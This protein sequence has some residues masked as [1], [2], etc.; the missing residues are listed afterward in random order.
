M[1]HNARGTVL[2]AILILTSVLTLA[3]I[4][5]TVLATSIDRNSTHSHSATSYPWW[6]T[7]RATGPPLSWYLA[8]E[9]AVVA[10]VIA[11]VAMSFRLLR[12][13]RRTASAEA[14]F[15]AV[16]LCAVSIESIRPFLA[17]VAPGALG[18]LIR[19]LL[20][21]ALYAG[22]LF[23]ALCL[24]ISSLYVLGV[25]YA[26]VETPFTI[27]ILVCLFFAYSLPLDSSE[28]VATPAYRLGDEGAVAAVFFSLYGFAAL[29]AVIGRF[30]GQ[31]QRGLVQAGAILLVSGGRDLLSFVTY[32][33]LAFVAVAAYVGGALLFAQRTQRRLFLM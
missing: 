33:A 27:T 13:F 10:A 7:Y 25:Q 1:T 20:S 3:G 19:M 15:F 9:A 5:S 31:E 24:F 23:G 18:N 6:F 4:A 21:R 32:P 11:A 26:R 17:L 2:T 12:I 28:A 22:R 8:T 30:R 29:N 14:Y 16:F